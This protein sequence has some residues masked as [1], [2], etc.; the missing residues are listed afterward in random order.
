MDLCLTCI[1]TEVGRVTEN[2]ASPGREDVGIVALFGGALLSCKRVCLTVL[3]P[4]D[5][6]PKAAR[7]LAIGQ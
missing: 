7:P 5:I 1:F 3:R 2:K 6:N 4:I